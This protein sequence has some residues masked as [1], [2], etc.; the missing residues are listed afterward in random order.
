MGL[1]IHYK[2][3]FKGSKEEL[4]KALE[5]VRQKCLDL[6]FEEVGEV[7]TTE[8]TQTMI[9]DWNETQQSGNFPNYTADDWKKIDAFREKWDVDTWTMIQATKDGNDKAKENVRFLVCPGEG[10]E[11]CELSFFKTR[12]AQYFRCS[13]FCKTQYATHFVRC[14]LA[15]VKMIDACKE[16]GIDVYD[17]DDEGNYYETRD[18]QKLAESLNKSTGV[19]KS[20]GSLLRDNFPGYI[21]MSNIDEC[22]NYMKVNKKDKK[23]SQE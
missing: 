3:R 14:H 23:D 17:V 2:M 10:S 15:L 12:R 9:D 6:P 20:V 1:T 21:I 13:G 8:I 16:E 4:A 22:E 19:I 11:T 18:L 7:E 5:R